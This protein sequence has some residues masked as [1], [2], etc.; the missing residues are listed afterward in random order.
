MEHIFGIW[1]RGL[2]FLK[3]RDDYVATSSREMA[4]EMARNIGPGA[5]VRCL[6]RSPE[7]NAELERLYLENEQRPLFGFIKATRK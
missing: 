1:R 3:V 6:D 5:S 2:G 7:V 4:G